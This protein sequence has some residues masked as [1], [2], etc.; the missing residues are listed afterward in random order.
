MP[1]T[2]TPHPSNYRIAG[3][4]WDATHAGGWRWTQLTG[5]EQSEWAKQVYPL[6]DA[7]RS[8]PVE[9]R[10][11]AMGMEPWWWHELHGLHDGPRHQSHGGLVACVPL[12][13]RD[14]NEP[15]TLDDLRTDG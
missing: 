10:M 1:E 12:Y 11:E 6:L 9:Q 2:T 14:L 7:I 8:L 4:L 13:A 5:G 3:V 15:P